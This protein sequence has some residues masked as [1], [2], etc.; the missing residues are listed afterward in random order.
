MSIWLPPSHAI[1][2]KPPKYLCCLCD[3]SFTED[4]RF[5]YE[6]HCLKAHDHAEVR[7][8]SPR[9]WAPGI[10]D[11]YH[12]SGDV[13]WQRWI[14]RHAAAGA[15]PMRYMKTSDGKSGGGTGDG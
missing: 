10:F 8:K 7:S 4:E 5:Q 6:R 13:E 2:N 11:P 14:D 15:D 12:E 9:D 3:A 1:H